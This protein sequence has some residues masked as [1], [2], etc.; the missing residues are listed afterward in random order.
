MSV[1]C[2]KKIQKPIRIGE[3]LRKKRLKKKL[4]LSD[5]EKE[6]LIP[7]KYLLA[8]EKNKIESLPQAKVLRVS[9]IKKYATLLGLDENKLSRQFCY[10]TGLDKYSVDHPNCRV[11][12]KSLNSVLFLCKRLGIV[13]VI[14]IFI[15][16][17]VWQVNGILKPPKLVLY[18]PI[19]GY[20][21]KDL[22]TLLQ[23]E[24]EKEVRLKVNGKDISTKENGKFEASIDLS[25]GI[26]AIT[27]TATKKH[28]K[29]T[30]LTRHVIVK[31]SIADKNKVTFK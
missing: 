27:I 10:E 1:F 21:S 2:L 29:S 19:E 9:Y 6:T 4:K 17:L 11:K 3:L 15:G 30:S 20:L 8:I 5:V 7:E 24:T 26:N 13:M 12:I 23:G 25:K 28:G 16:Y 14:F 31:E 22:K 18:S